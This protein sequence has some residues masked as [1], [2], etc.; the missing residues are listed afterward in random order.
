MKHFHFPRLLFFFLLPFLPRQK[1]QGNQYAFAKYFDV[2]EPAVFSVKKVVT[3]IILWVSYG[4]GGNDPC[5][6]CIARF[7]GTSR[8]LLCCHLP[9]EPFLKMNNIRNN[10]QTRRCF[11]LCALWGS[12][13]LPLVVVHPRDPLP[14]DGPGRGDIAAASSLDPVWNSSSLFQL[15]LQEVVCIKTSQSLIT[16]LEHPWGEYL[17]LDFLEY[18]KVAA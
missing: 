5:T 9:M 12:L 16:G 3:K 7:R 17:R 4:C 13:S 15:C 2:S 18:Q 8:I 11:Y 10:P 14:R 6:S 1:F